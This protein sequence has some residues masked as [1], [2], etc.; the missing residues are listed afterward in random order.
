MAKTAAQ[1]IA[2]AEAEV[3]Y[4]EKKS[5]AMLDDKTANAGSNN[6][7]KYARDLDAIP[8]FYNGKKQGYPWCD[9][10]F[11]WLMVQCFG[12]ETAK[13][14]LGQPDKSYGAG[15]GYSAKYY[16][17]K[18]RF[19]TKD[20]KPGD[21]IFFWDSGKTKV[22]HTGLVYKVDSTKVYTIEGNTSGASGVVANGG[23]VCKKSYKLSYARI[24]GYGRPPYDDEEDTIP[25]DVKEEECN[26][27]VRVLKKGSK[28]ADV[29]SLQILLI[30]YGY[31]CGKAG[32]DGDFGSATDTA[33][34]SYQNYNKLEVDGIVGQKTWSKLLGV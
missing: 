22:A 27:N 15:C 6:Y 28:G 1:V 2:L 10:W 33:V 26:V 12:V 3:G 16:K 24:Y 23:G 13:E 30:G 31:S 11:D 25:V 21:Q 20:P 4:L 17:A 34:K 19:F 8:N 29:K 18:N 9:V 7:T 5:N 32:V 14:M